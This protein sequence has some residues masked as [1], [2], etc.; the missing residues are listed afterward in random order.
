MV[1]CDLCGD[2]KAV[3]TGVIENSELFL[4]DNCRLY[5]VRI[6]KIQSPK[7]VIDKKSVIEKEQEEIVLI[8]NF[9]K[10]IRD[11]REKKGLTIEDAAKQLKIKENQLRM[12]EKNELIPDDDLVER[13]SRFYNVIL[14]TK[15]T[16]KLPSKP[17]SSVDLTFGDMIKLK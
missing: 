12:L 6:E 11:K 16:V 8:K 15:T 7:P 5:A 3:C 1:Q 17:T 14:K 4:C 2:R 10:V 9:H 13:L